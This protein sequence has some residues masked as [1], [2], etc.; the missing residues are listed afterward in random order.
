[1]I[2]ATTHKITVP[3]PNNRISDFDV[4]LKELIKE[5]VPKK[6]FYVKG[7]FSADDF[8]FKGVV[9]IYEDTGDSSI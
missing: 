8:I 9:T 3:I 5:E 1:M 7:E 2:R 4:Y 6:D